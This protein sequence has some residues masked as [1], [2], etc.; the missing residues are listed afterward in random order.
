MILH[1]LIQ[2]LKIIAGYKFIYKKCGD[3]YKLYCYNNAHWQNDDILLKIC[4]S[5]ELYEFLKTILIEVY[6][7]SP[8]FQTT[9]KKLNKLKTLSFK[10]DIVQTYKEYGINNEIKFD[11]KWWLLGF[12]NKVYDMELGDFRDYKYEDYVSVTCAQNY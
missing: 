9:I 4:I 11:D 5:N 10:K 3:N 2:S 7:K 12:N 1:S 6:W 8:Q